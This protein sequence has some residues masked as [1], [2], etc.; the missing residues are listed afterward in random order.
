[1]TS[2][3]VSPSFGGGG[4]GGGGGGSSP[5]VVRWVGVAD[6]SAGPPTALT[7]LVLVDQTFHTSDG[8]GS[9]VPVDPSPLDGV[10]V[11]DG[12]LVIILNT[13]NGIFPDSAIGVFEVHDGS[14]WERQTVVNNGLVLV[15]N[16]GQYEWST[17]AMSYSETD[18]G[19]TRINSLRVV[20]P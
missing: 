4:G 19:G 7:D 8:F 6:M 2:Y 3:P 11:T 14:A 12:D 10:A 17:V 18:T 1:M 16:C 15:D 5:T 13:N 20:S 9:A